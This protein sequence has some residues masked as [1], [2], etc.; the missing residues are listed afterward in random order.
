[1]ERAEAENDRTWGAPPKEQKPPKEKKLPKQKKPKPAP[2]ELS[3][4]TEPVPLARAAAARPLPQLA[5]ACAP[6]A[7]AA[8]T[9]RAIYQGRALYTKAARYI[10]R[11]RA[12]KAASCS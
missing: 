6:A 5:A 7:A 8:A 4:R 10:P 1:M 12:T 3:S 2:D 9:P 11:P